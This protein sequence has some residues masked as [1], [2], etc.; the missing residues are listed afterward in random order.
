MVRLDVGVPE[1]RRETGRP[2]EVVDGQATQAGGVHRGVTIAADAGATRVEITEDDLLSLLN[3]AR[4]RAASAA[5]I[6]VT[7]NTV[8]DAATE[9]RETP[10]E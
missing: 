9:K 2:R 7:A 4:A 10:G 6:A 5:P 1:P 8:P 3:A